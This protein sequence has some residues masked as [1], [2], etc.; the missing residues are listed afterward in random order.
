MRSLTIEEVARGEVCTVEPD[1]TVGAVVETM[2]ERNVGSVVVVD[3]G[4]PVGIVTDREIALAIPR[5]DDLAGTAV[6]ELLGDDLVTATTDTDAFEVLDTMNEQGI[7]RIPV[8]DD[9]GEL[10]GIITLDD[11]LVFLGSNLQT[12]SDTITEQFPQS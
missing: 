12:V 2:E 5:L 9:D 8:V 11:M 7:R 3:D 6:E 1:E 4:A 10:V